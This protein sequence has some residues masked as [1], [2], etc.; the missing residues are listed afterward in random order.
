LPEV[1]ATIREPAL[2][3]LDA[4]YSGGITSGSDE[5]CPVLREL[6]LIFNNGVRE[7][8]VLV[9]DARLFVGE[10]GYPTVEQVASLA[11]SHSDRRVEV[12]ND[13]IRITPTARHRK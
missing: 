10:K 5:Y 4:H 13:V 11:A 7:H 1:L 2:F 9:D 12:A 8:V 3:W 6:E